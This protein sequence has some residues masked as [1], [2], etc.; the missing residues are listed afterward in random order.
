MP[1][2]IPLQQLLP[3]VSGTCESPVCHKHNGFTLVE[4]LVAIAI[5]ALMSVVAYSGLNS[6]METD[7]ATRIESDRLKK[8]QTGLWIMTRDLH[9]AVDRGV[10]DELGDPIE[11][12][13]GGGFTEN[14]LAFTYS[15]NPNPLNKRVSSLKRVRYSYENHKLIRVTSEVL[16]SVQDSPTYKSTLL[17]GIDELQFRF[18]D[19]NQQWHDSWPVASSNAKSPSPGMPLAVEIN[20]VDSKWGKITRLVS[21]P[22]Y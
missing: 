18:M 10:R 22:G 15:G 19:S 13:V 9:H 12:F 14:S 5:F 4:L 2:K 11:S 21:L 20:M 1:G 16:D 8:L 3:Q 7:K 17:D 6:I